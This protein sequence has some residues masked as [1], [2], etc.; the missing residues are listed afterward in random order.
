M[1]LYNYMIYQATNWLEIFNNAVRAVNQSL[2]QYYESK[3]LAEK[4][5]IENIFNEN[6]G[7]LVQ[8][9]FPD[10]EFSGN[11]FQVMGAEAKKAFM[12]GGDEGARVFLDNAKNKLRMVGDG[13]STNLTKKS[14]QKFSG[15]LDSAFNS[16]DENLNQAILNQEKYQNLKDN[17]SQFSNGFK[18]SSD[19]QTMKQWVEF[20]NEKKIPASEINRAIEN[21]Y[22]GAV[23][24][25]DRIGLKSLADA[26]DNQKLLLSGNN[27]MDIA[28]RRKQ[29]QQS[30]NIKSTTASI[31]QD[32]FSNPN[33]PEFQQASNLLTSVVSKN[34]K[35]SG[36]DVI[37]GNSAGNQIDFGD[38]TLDSLKDWNTTGGF[39]YNKKV[40]KNATN[41]L[42]PDDV[43]DEAMALRTANR[44]VQSFINPD[45]IKKFRNNISNPKPEYKVQSDPKFQN[46]KGEFDETLVNQ[47]L[48]KNSGVD[49]SYSDIVNRCM[50]QFGKT[51]LKLSD[52]VVQHCLSEELNSY[53]ANPID[54]AMGKVV[55]SKID[56]GNHF[57]KNE[58]GS[59]TMIDGNS[60]QALINDAQSFVGKVSPKEII[61][62]DNKK[63]SLSREYIDSLI[64]NF[65]K[66]DH[67]AF[68][69][70]YKKIILASSLNHIRIPDSSKH[71]SE[72]DAEIKMIDLLNNPNRDGV[73]IVKDDKGNLEIQVDGKS[74]AEYLY[75]DQFLPKKKIGRNSGSSSSSSSNNLNSIGENVNDPTNDNANITKTPK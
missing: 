34:D 4:S 6:N 45:D 52:A 31:A 35:Q 53:G 64:P 24:Q 22:V 30:L 70:N 10:T 8:Q 57:I 18:N 60:M 19:P 75:P 74:L 72:I 36:L 55:S 63:R 15:V 38:V 62:G 69:G 28:D 68:F 13:L 67:V 21:K 16:I 23:M 73:E 17:I 9:I 32:L 26:T 29:T 58:D 71:L 56:E 61:G 44:L 5:K 46:S 54:V 11:V 43:S 12:N 2:G 39:A 33:S 37:F 65:L 59:S 20:A 66:S 42:D 1:D 40:F 48:K 50:T 41:Q 3:D 14:A 7:D 51:G 25:G 27:A 49:V 47:L